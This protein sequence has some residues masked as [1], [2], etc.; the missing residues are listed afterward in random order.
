MVLRNPTKLTIILCPN[1]CYAVSSGVRPHIDKDDGRLGDKLWQLLI[2]RKKQLCIL[3]VGF[4][5]EKLLFKLDIFPL[6]PPGV[7][8]VVTLWV[9]KR[10]I[11]NSITLNPIKGKSGRN[12]TYRNADVTF[13]C[14]FLQETIWEED[15][16]NIC[17]F[18]HRSEEVRSLNPM[19][20]ISLL[21]QF[22]HSIA[23]VM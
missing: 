4:L 9:L 19:D 10:G 18:E 3:S 16:S 22:P 12:S 13:E 1:N 7:C 17:S 6:I 23:Y 21:K 2:E 5:S 14:V 20:Q 15:S 8:V 11:V